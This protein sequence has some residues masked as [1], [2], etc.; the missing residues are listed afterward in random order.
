MLHQRAA[1]R[2]NL[3]SFPV[4]W[5]DVLERL[6]AITNSPDG[7]AVLAHDEQTLAQLMRFEYRTSP[8]S[9]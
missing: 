4:H 7:V 3:A 5:D 6:I 2:G 9:N 8:F 1:V